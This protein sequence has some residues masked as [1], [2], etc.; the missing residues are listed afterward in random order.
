MRMQ[1]CSRCGGYEVINLKDKDESKALSRPLAEWK[2]E[3][4]RPCCE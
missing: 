2:A 3:E 4:R 1:R